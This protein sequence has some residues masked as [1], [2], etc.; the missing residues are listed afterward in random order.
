MTPRTTLH[1]VCG[2]VASGK[3]TFAR[4]LAVKLGTVLVQEDV[5][6]SGLYA[7]ELSTLRDYVRCSERLRQTMKP[8]IVELLQNGLNVVLDF[9]A[10]TLEIRHWMKTLIETAECDHQLH[11]FDVSDDVCKTRLRSRNKSGDHQFSVS[12]A[13]FDRIS[14]HFQPPSEEEGFKMTVYSSQ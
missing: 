8:H 11:V 4:S 10:N 1:L 14:S 7:D 12:E 5:W 3:S 6:L 13:E 2:K 9:P